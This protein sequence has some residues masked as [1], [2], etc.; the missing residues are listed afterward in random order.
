MRTRLT[1][2]LVLFFC[3]WTET[4]SAQTWT[5]FG[6]GLSYK[7]ILLPLDATNVTLHALK[8]DPKKLRLRPIHSTTAAS[9]KSLA[10]AHKAI[11]VINANFFDTASKP[12]GLVVIDGKVT[13]P[14][15][16]ISWWSVFCVKGDKPSILHGDAYRDG[17][18]DQAVEAG[19]RLVVNGQI[20]QLKDESSRKTAI[21]ITRDGK[22]V[23]VATDGRLPIKRL[24]T[25]FQ[26]SEAQGGLGCPNAI[27]MDG[28]TSTQI[29]ADIG[30]FRLDLPSFVGVPVGLAVFKK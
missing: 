20:P 5:D 7:K 25:L 10:E 3:V 8:L 1:L 2:L 15:K 16:K 18:C 11:A 28:G 13:H 24:A 22:V 26:K 9:V 27:N 19:P 29:Y 6:K 30:G 4:A 17:L 14:F 12:L 23:L 21:G